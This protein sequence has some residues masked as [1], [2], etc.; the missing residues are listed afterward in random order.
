M[1]AHSLK[2]WLYIE[3]TFVQR[4]VFTRLAQQWCFRNCRAGVSVVL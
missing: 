2:C 4:L 1:L 3:A